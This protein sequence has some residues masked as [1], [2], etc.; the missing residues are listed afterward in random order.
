MEIGYYKCKGMNL[1]RSNWGF[2]KTRSLKLMDP[3]LLQDGRQSSLE[4]GK[5]NHPVQKGLIIDI[6][7]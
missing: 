3:D 1:Q 4:D 5:I 6:L 2:C 7:N